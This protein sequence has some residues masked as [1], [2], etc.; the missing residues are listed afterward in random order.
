MK[1]LKCL[2]FILFICQS[3]FSQN[4]TE[5]DLYTT[6]GNSQYVKDIAIMEVVPK[7]EYNHQLKKTIDFLDRE[8]SEIEKKDS[9]LVLPC[10]NGNVTYTDNHVEDESFVE[11]DYIGQI[12]FLNVYVVEYVL[13]ESSGFMFVD[14]TTGEEI[15][16]FE[17]YPYISKD[18]NFIVIVKQDPYEGS[19]Y[20]SFYKIKEKEIVQ[21]VSDNFE[22]WTPYYDKDI[23]WGE[24]NSLYIP[25][26]HMSVYN[27]DKEP[28]EYCQYIKLTLK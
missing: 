9:L 19:A 17:E 5:E 8:K 20:M 26:L 4:L 28:E 7:N 16:T 10:K 23:F 25:A 21:V 15:E 3:V 14:K 13:W 24:D 11:Y 27:S 18:K 2:L 12:P 1:T 6:Y 22:Y